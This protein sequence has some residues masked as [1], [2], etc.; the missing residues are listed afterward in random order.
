[1]MLAACSSN[2]LEEPQDNLVT[3]D[4]N[5]DG[6]SVDTEQMTRTTAPVG[7]Y[8]TH[9]DVWVTDGTNNTAYNQISSDSGFGSLSLT[10]NNT[11]TYTIYAVAHRADGAAT[12]TDGVIS[13]P[14]DKVTHSFF[15][16]QTFTPTNGMSLNLTMNRIVAQFQLKTSDAVPDYVKKMRFTI[17]DVYDRW[18]VSTG[19]TH[20]IDRVSTINITSTQPDGTIICNV[21]AIVTGENTNHDVLMESLDADDQVR[22]SHTLTNIP[23]CNN[24]RTIATGAFF[25]DAASSFSFLAD[26]WGGEIDYNF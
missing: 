1:M 6:F 3:V 24:K 5:M 11:K 10:L 14:S 20:K 25:V 21:Y 9:L 19:G 16:S 2:K 8:C 13:F 4:V 15:V 26:E 7:D 22:E 17:S 12:L 18:N 23:L